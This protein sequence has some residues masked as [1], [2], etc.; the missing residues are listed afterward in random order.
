MWVEVCCIRGNG[1]VKNREDD[2]DNNG[3]FWAKRKTAVGIVPSAG[4]GAFVGRRQD[5]CKAQ[6]EM[7]CD[8]PPFGSVSGWRMQGKRQVRILS[9]KSPVP[10]RVQALS[11]TLRGRA[12]GL[13]VE[14]GRKIHGCGKR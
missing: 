7:R 9:G 3:T 4:T 6:A 10:G 1:C 5:K 12:W 8:G 14:S 2:E 11:L 13:G